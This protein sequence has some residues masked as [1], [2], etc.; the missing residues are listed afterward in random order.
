M[1]A[2]ETKLPE[3]WASPNKKDSGK[4]LAQ[5]EFVVPS[6]KPGTHC[7]AFSY[8]THHCVGVTTT[9]YKIGPH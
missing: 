1:L 7:L 9:P 5:S 2:L 4:I 3:W 8:G 6:M